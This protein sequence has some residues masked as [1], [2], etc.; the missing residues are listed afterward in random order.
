MNRLCMVVCRVGQPA[1]VE[2]WPA[3][4]PRDYFLAGTLTVS[5]AWMMPLLDVMSRPV[6]VAEPMRTRLPSFVIDAVWPCIMVGA[7]SFSTS[8]YEARPGIR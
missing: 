7:V 3:V 8:T 6:I 4:C 1:I 5:T 2:R